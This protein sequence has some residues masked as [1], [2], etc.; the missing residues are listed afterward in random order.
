MSKFTLIATSAFGLESVVVKE[1]KKLGYSDF[2][3]FNGGV[4]FSGDDE[5]LCTCN[6]WLRS[7]DRVFM[8]LAEFKALSFEELFQQVKAIPW[9][10]YLREDAT[11]PVYAK[12]VKSKLFSL[13][14]IQSISKK[15][16]VESLKENYL[17]QWFEET[18]PRFPIHISI[19]N[20]RVKVLLDTSGD[21]L[22]KRGYRVDSV[23][24]PL[25]E[26]MAAALVLLSNWHSDKVLIDPFCGSG[27]IPIEAALIGR[28]IAP[29][30]NRKFISETWDFIPDQVWKN[31]RQKAYAAIDLDKPLKIQGYDIDKHAVRAAKANAL[32]AGLEDAIHFQVRNVD[33]LSSGDKKGCIITNPPYGERLE[34]KSAVE[35]LYAALG[36][37][38]S[39]LEGWSY[40]ILT[41]HEHFESAFG[42]RADKNRKLYNG[43][44]KSYYYQYFNKEAD[45]NHV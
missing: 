38:L 11:F 3:T 5:A 30:L 15:A 20:D 19:L 9:K 32:E 8:K 37:R 18:G 44:I 13:S 14:D 23:K 26:T 27:T 12:S 1:L 25:K 40:F 16:V 17:T 22:H 36:K 24:A 45:K 33:E 4:E 43:R 10:N 21:G 29:G 34:T 39:L 2:Q 28:N 31:A 42:L 41:A 6:L 7:A 35:H